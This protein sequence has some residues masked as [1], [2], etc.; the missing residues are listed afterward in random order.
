MTVTLWISLG[1][2]AIASILP[3]AYNSRFLFGGSGWIF[4]AIYWSLQPPSYTEIQDYF[5][6]FL[7]VVAAIL[8]L[9]IA[10]ITFQARN[11][12]GESYEVLISLSRAASVGG[13]IY[14]LFVD[15]DFLNVGIISLVTN[16]TIWVVEQL[17]FPVAQVAWNQLAVNGLAVEI[18]L[19][20]TAI[21]SIALF[22]G[23][24][25][26]ATR[27]AL[28][29]KFKAFMISVPV[30]Y[31]L[32]LLR[33][34]FTASAY[35]FAWFGTPDESF[36]ITEHFIAK[37]GS[38]IALFIISYMILK[39]LPEITDMIDGTVKMLRIEFRRLAMRES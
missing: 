12:K 30:I 2:L 8:S 24:I 33:T 22:T 36:H 7:V 15:V 27:T 18:I 13:L 25:S 17:G 10:Y 26:S 28:T 5:N 11:K 39:M 3:K 14:F 34:S 1:F 21:E 20:C 37:I 32:N 31:A 19:A 4:L 35:G 29:Q 16:Q 9:F 6:A 38:L 23:L